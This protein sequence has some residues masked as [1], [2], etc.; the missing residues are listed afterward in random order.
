LGLHWRNCTFVPEQKFSEM[1]GQLGKVGWPTRSRV[2]LSGGRVVAGFLRTLVGRAREYRHWCLGDQ[3]TA[4]G[5]KGATVVVISIIG[6]KKT[7]S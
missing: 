4:G 1:A 2:F 3:F 5:R 6:V 7:V